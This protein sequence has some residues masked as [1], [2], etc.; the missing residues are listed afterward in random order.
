LVLKVSIPCRKRLTG[1]DACPELELFTHSSVMWRAFVTSAV[2]AVSL[3]YV[4]PFGT[5]KLVLFQVQSKDVWRSFELV[6]C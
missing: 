3:Q 6:R 2:A 5:S 1:P 4:D